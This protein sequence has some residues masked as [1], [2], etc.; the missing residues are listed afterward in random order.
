MRPDEA[1]AVTDLIGKLGERAVHEKLHGKVYGNEQGYLRQ[2]NFEL[3]LKYQKQQR[4]KVVY[5]PLRYVPE[6]ARRA[7][8]IIAL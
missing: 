2:R 3:P 4:R 5:D 7:G 1:D 6:I 8:M